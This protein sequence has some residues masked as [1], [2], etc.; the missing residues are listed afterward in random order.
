MTVGKITDAFMY[1][2]IVSEIKETKCGAG[3]KAGLVCLKNDHYSIVID[4]S[5]RDFTLNIINLSLH[6]F[7][8]Y[9]Y[10]Y[11][12]KLLY[13]DNLYMF[14][15]SAKRYID[16]RPD[17]DKF[18]GLG[19]AIP[20][21]YDPNNDKINST[22]VP[23]LNSIPLSKTVEGILD[24]PITFIMKNVEA[25]ALSCVR[26]IPH[27][28][29][30]VVIYMY[31]GEC[32]DGAVCNRGNFVK[33]A[34]NAECDFGRMILRY[35]ETLESRIRQNRSDTEM[36]NELSSA[37]YNIIT[38]LDPDAFIIESDLPKNPAY[39]INQ[40]KYYLQESY[41]LENLPEFI[42]GGTNFRHSARGVALKLRDIWLDSII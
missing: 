17:K 27:Y 38:I 4:L 29:D 35:G 37:V 3:R 15:K 6:L 41:G 34:H 14:L 33:G 19:I 30:K 7:D 22:K 39:I 21:D 12:T 24:I 20:G 1:L 13:D 32:I 25:A 28:D 42:S 23:E 26:S 5:E 18:I 36:V 9:T 40:L 11:N 2:G 31:M 16:S 8:S 10:K